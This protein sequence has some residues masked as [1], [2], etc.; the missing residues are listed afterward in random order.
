[1]VPKM[2]NWY[3][4]I[5][6]AVLNSVNCMSLCTDPLKISSWIKF[7]IYFSIFSLFYK[8]TIEVKSFGRQLNLFYNMSN[9]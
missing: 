6:W 7:H 5:Y 2:R 1:M 9:S 4:I 8:D 3:C